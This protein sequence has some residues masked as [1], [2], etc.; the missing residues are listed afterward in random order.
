MK[1]L[2][3]PT[4]LRQ[5]LSGERWR[6]IDCRFDLDDP[7]WG[8]RE[9]EREHLPGPVYASLDED[10][11]APAD[12]SNGRHPLPSPARLAE[13]F[14]RM[15]IGASTRA[16]A[17]DASGGPFAARLWWLIRY[18]GHREVAVLDG[19]LPAWKRAGYPLEGSQVVVEPATFKPLPRHEIV[20]DATAVLD[21]LQDPTLRLID[22]RSP[23][24]FRGEQE[25][26][27]PVAGRIPGAVSRFWQNNPTPQ[28]TLLPADQLGHEFRELLGGHDPRRAISYCGS[29][30]TA[31]HNLLAM[32]A[33]GHPLPQRYA[34]SRSEWCADPARPT[35][36]G[37]SARED[38]SSARARQ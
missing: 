18:L 34:G 7:A 36:S 5:G 21:H 32:A 11:S 37:A 15:G 31:A 14:S 10:L 2:I 19:G 1:P 27:D 22:A 23:E 29:G 17:Y 38:R 4:E 24:R 16:V 25:P 8:R 13:T 30:V 35:A 6:I 33:A 12:G 28:G 9:Y 3:S 20:V 26:R